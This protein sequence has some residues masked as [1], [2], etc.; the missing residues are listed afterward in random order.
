MTKRL[1]SA[2]VLLEVMGQSEVS[3]GPMLCELSISP[4]IGRSIV[5]S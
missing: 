5:L 4:R 2:E 3:P 1:D